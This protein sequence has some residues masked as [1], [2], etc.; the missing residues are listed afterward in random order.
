MIK[1]HKIICL[2][3]SSRFKDDFLREQSRLILQGNMVIGIPML[4]SDD[5]ISVDDSI[6]TLLDDIRRQEIIMCDEIF[7]INKKDHIETSTQKEIEYA[8]I[9]GKPINYMEEHHE[10]NRQNLS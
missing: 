2:C 5:H 3:G 4:W 7:V 8:L 10:K 6:K 1:K 9:C